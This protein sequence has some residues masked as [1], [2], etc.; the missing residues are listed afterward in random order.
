MRDAF[1]LAREKIKNEDKEGAIIFIDEIDAIG[2]KVRFV[3]GWW[4]EMVDEMI[5][6]HLNDG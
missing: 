5:L 1:D 3:D 2:T 6:F 4:D